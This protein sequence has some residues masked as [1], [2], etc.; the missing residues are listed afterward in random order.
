MEKPFETTQQI[1]ATEGVRVL[2]VDDV[3]ANLIVASDFLAQ[4]RISADTAEDGPEAIEMVKKSLDEKRPCDLIFMDHMMPGMDGIEATHR[5]REFERA[6][7]NEN[8]GFP[9]V[10]VICLSA[11]AVE[12]SEKIFLSSGMNG[13]ISKPIESVNLDAALRKFSPERKHT[14]VKD[15]RFTAGKPN[16]REERIR[17]ELAKIEGLDIK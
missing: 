9:H 7:R 8:R 6:R 10:P 16:K 4:C 11:N 15:D 5:I 13:F 12:R 17:E 3:P 2:V 1:V 14:I